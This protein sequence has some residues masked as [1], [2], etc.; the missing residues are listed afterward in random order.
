MRQTKKTPTPSTAQELDGLARTYSYALDGTIVS[1]TS[2]ALKQIAIHR[3]DADSASRHERRRMAAILR[4]DKLQAR[5]NK[6]IQRRLDRVERRAPAK[7][8]R[9]SVEPENRRKYRRKQRKIASKSI[10]PLPKYERPILDRQGRCGIVMVIDYDGAKRHAFGIVGR[11]IIYI[12]DP[13][14]CEFD[15][16]GR[17]VFFSNMGADLDEILMGADLLELVQRESRADAKLDVNIIVQLPHDVP[18]EVRAAILKAVAHELFGR[19]GLPYAASLHRPDP[20]GDQRNNHGHICGSWRPMTRV[21]P[22]GWDIAEDYRADLDGAEYWR[23][24]RRRVAEIMTATLERAGTERH[25]THLSNAERGLPHKPQKK[26][27]KRKTRAA[28]ENEFVADVE[29]NRRTIKAN[30]ALETKL[31]AKRQQRRERALKRRLAVL[32]GVELA[33]VRQVDLRPVSAV[34]SDLAAAIIRPV[35]TPQTTIA[36]PLRAVDTVRAPSTGAPVIAAIDPAPFR[37]AGHLRKVAPAAANPLS[38]TTF[39]PVSSPSSGIVARLKPVR[40]TSQRASIGGSIKP[41]AVASGAAKPV[42]R[43]VGPPASKDEGVKIGPVKPM[44]TVGELAAVVQPAENPAPTITDLRPVGMPSKGRVTL[45]PVA[46]TSAPRIEPVS[47][48]S[49][50]DPNE[51]IAKPVS[52]P[53][54]RAPVLT[55]VLPAQP[56]AGKALKPVSQDAIRPPIIA[57]VSA[58]IT[59]VWPVLRPVSAVSSTAPLGRAAHLKPVAPLKEQGKIG[60]ALRPVPTVSP[61]GRESDLRP[62]APPRQVGTADIRAVLPPANTRDAGPT[63]KRVA[64]PQ[65][66]FASALRP[67]APVAPIGLDPAL[68]ETM[69]A[70][71]ERLARIAEVRSRERGPD[72][73]GSRTD[74]V[75]GME[76]R[77]D[78]G[79]SST[80]SQDELAREVQT[81]RAFVA[82][83]K[84]KAIHVG[85]DE[86]GLILPQPVYWSGNGLTRRGLSDP[87]VQAELV[88][89]ER[90]QAAYMKHIHPILRETVTAE[91]LAKGSPAILAQLP[92]E[93]RVAAQTWAKTGIWSRLMQWV[94][95]E[96]EQ[97]SRR[98]L[99]RWRKA[100]D[101]ADGSHFASAAK[102]EA[103]LSK[104]PVDVTWKDR[105]SLS[106]DARQHRASLA[107]QQAAARQGGIV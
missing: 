26:L 2:A 105:Q 84:N 67:V 100:R 7:K 95:E 23:H 76:D 19:H 31:E 57:K 62:V 51:N 22:Y 28:R 9:I 89:M 94:F 64:K 56:L 14:H 49:G 33:R 97:C 3:R 42:L 80:P 8:I 99:R 77:A 40:Q 1:L 92:E 39:K 103:Q 43:P 82:R 85:A 78:R 35:G 59:A 38:M 29:A 69:R 72:A 86:E 81:A 71:G 93:E 13:E 61:L 5:I 50:Q 11:R 32:A 44:E 87:Q 37:I 36:T 10:V 63:V 27:D 18:Q 79:A 68:A 17:P 41:V 46:A 106:M 21:A 66:G 107:A 104:W 12:S 4:D 73:S 48:R 24:A 16:L 54:S 65:T 101:K 88:R 83:V 25:Y 91:L 60:P 20:D 55:P 58:K 6:A 15:A 70:F 74:T 52:P 34:N 30:V 45:R 75:S 98:D 102:A 53:T 47:V 96:G 90:R